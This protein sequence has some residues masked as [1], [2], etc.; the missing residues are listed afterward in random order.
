MQGGGYGG[1]MLGQGVAEV[2]AEIRVVDCIMRNNKAERGGAIYI[3][4][5]NLQTDNVTFVKN[6]VG[7]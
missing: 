6:K 3:E 7:A 4:N 2:P 5:A 1:V